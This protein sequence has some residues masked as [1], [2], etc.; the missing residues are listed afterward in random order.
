M[1]ISQPTRGYHLLSALPKKAFLKTAEASINDLLLGVLYNPPK[2]V[3][4][5][6]KLVECVL[7]GNSK[8]Y[9]GKAYT[10]EQVLRKWIRS[11]A[12]RK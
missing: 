3:V 11:S 5:R 6:Q 4:K 12:I 1:Y 9:L 2:S 8:Q 7:T 10:K